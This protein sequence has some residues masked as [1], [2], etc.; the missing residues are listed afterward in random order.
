MH[1]KRPGLIY[2][3]QGLAIITSTIEEILPNTPIDYV[4]GT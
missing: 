1:N 4:H 3:G 2:S